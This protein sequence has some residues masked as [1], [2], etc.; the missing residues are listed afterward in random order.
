[1]L[2]KTY[3]HN[4]WICF[5]FENSLQECVWFVVS[6]LKNM[7]KRRSDPSQTGTDGAA[8]LTTQRAT[9]IWVTARCCLFVVTFAL[10]HSGGTVRHYK[11]M[12]PRLP[13]LLSY[14]TV[15]APL[16]FMHV[17]WHG[18]SPFSPPFFFF[19]SLP[20][21]PPPMTTLFPY[22]HYPPMILFS[23]PPSWWYPSP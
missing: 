22:S 14:H 6:G 9:N 17:R 3:G 10:L 15:V 1:M 12:S 2:R 20:A 4:R 23:F 19:S 18:T 21:S 7:Q 11:L 16:L 5:C 8:S 13:C